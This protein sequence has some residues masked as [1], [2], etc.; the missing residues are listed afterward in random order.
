LAKKLHVL[1]WTLD[2]VPDLPVETLG[3]LASS[4]GDEWSAVTVCYNEQST[5]VVNPRHSTGRTSSDL[6]HELS[7][8]MLD[9][10]AGETYFSGD[11]MMRE[12]DEKQEAEADWLA[13][14]ILLPRKALEHIKHD[15]L[16][17]EQVTETYGVSSQLY[18][19]RCRM[20][21]INRQYS[22]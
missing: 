17:D 18:I 9:H 2:N 5:I 4:R 10:K 13:G 12:Y 21:A 8:I 19:Y 22:R 20:T 3:F 1:I 15:H 11:F 7:H 16:S 6:M 14:A